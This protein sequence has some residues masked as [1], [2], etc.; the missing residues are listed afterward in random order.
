SSG[1]LKGFS[2]AEGHLDKTSMYA[3]IKGGSTLALGGVNATIDSSSEIRLDRATGIS[4]TVS[5]AV[6]FPGLDP[7]AVTIAPKG[8]GGRIDSGK[9]ALEPG[10]KLNGEIKAHTGGAAGKGEAT[11]GWD[12]G[13][14]RWAAGGEVELGEVTNHILEGRVAA[15]AGAGAHTKLH[16]L[17]PITV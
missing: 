3:V 6:N 13:T 2:L 1:P 9:V 8:K 7:I 12:H 5:G 14:F 11:I 10:K 16:S 15:S 17:G 4:G